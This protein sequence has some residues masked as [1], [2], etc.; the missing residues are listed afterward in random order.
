[1]T[2]INEITEALKTNKDVTIIKNKLPFYFI[3]QN[4]SCDIRLFNRDYLS[5]IKSNQEEKLSEVFVG[6]CKVLENDTFDSILE[7]L[8]MGM[9]IIYDKKRD[10]YYFFDLIN[11][12]QRSV[13]ES[14]SEP[15]AI[16]GPRDGF[17]E[18]IKI[19]IVLIRNRIKDESLNIDE[20]YIGR[21]SKT[22]INVL[23]LNGI[24]NKSYLKATIS[25]LE[26]IDVDGVYSTQDITS[27]FQK[28]AI[29][30]K[31]LYLGSPDLVARHL[32]DGEVIILIDGIPNVIVLPNTI[33]S[34]LKLRLEQ[35]NLKSYAILLR[36][37]V[38]ISFFLA[39]A[40]LGVLVS[41]VT[42]QSDSLSLLLISTLKVTQ[43]GVFIP[44]YMEII[45]VLFLFELYYIVSFK[46]PKL[47]LSSMVVLVGGII[48]GQNTVMSGMVGVFIIT[49]VAL[50]FLASFTI[51]SNVT[52][53][54]SIS[55]IRSFLLIASLF[56]GFF[57]F[58]IALIYLVVRISSETTYKVDYFY[59][60]IPWNKKGVKKFFMFESNL[61]LKTR[62]DEL[63]V[64]NKRKKR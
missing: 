62:P 13:S 34:F 45:L 26:Q 8:F 24:T 50:S 58:T 16:T 57:G 59:P 17:V 38:L 14:I 27:Y 30:P 64:K 28:N 47:T 42:F 56:L 9:M 29:M 15:D 22:R 7:L 4:D 46:S 31:Y 55:L 20:L 63:K 21:I 3:Y 52:F 6:V 33:N 49:L 32:T 43:K 11:K 41:F 5:I 35:V 54:M 60:F 18:G 48:I 10:L 1:M 23:S 2:N 51:S 12:P 19:N 40:F 39:T 37:F 36:V 25:I 53:V 61:N 44:V